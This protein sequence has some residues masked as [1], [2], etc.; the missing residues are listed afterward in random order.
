ALD[1]LVEAQII[2]ILRNLR[3]EF[4]TSLLLITHNLGIIAETCDRVAVMYAGK[5]VEIGDATQVFRE[6]A[7]PH[8][9]SLLASTISPSTTPLHCAA[10]RTPARAEPPSACR[11]HPRCPHAMRICADSAPIDT[12][13]ADDHRVQCWLHGPGEFMTDERAKALERQEIASADEA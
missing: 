9:Q 13:V 1:V 7:H 5:I 12:D 10:G 6:P 8:T 2:R 3:H 11:S 4:D